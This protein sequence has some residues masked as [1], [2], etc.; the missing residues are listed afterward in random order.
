MMV[1]ESLLM[2]ALLGSVLNGKK[3]GKAYNE[4]IKELNRG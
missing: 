3:G 2:Q 1:T 4:M